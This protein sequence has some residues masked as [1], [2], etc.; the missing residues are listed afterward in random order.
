MLVPMP[1]QMFR[2][3]PEPGEAVEKEW[4]QVTF[5]ED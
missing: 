4:L 3:R 5:C 2:V 1:L